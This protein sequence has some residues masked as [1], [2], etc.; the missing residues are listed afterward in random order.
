MLFLARSYAPPANIGVPV[1]VPDHSAPNGVRVV[2]VNERA[3]AT[4]AYGAMSTGYVLRGQVWRL[5][6]SQYLHASMMHLLLNMLGLYFFG[7]PLERLWSRQK[8]LII[9]T[10]AGL[11]GNLL[12]MAIGLIGWIHPFAP[13]VGASGCILGLLGICAVMFPHA[14]VY[15]Y[16][17]F[18]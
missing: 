4:F 5:V 3:D 12:L 18:P 11:L 16:F 1:E 15:V 7:R 2:V 17:L 9:Y 10:L 14:E 13:A 6:T 8:F